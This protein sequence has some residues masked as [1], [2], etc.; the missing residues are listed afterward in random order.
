MLEAFKDKIQPLVVAGSVPPSSA[1]L[2]GPQAGQVPANPSVFALPVL[3]LL[4]VSLQTL[5]C[6]LSLKNGEGHL[7]GSV[8]EH[9]PLA[10]GVILGSWDQVQH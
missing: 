2:S 7:S 8:V 4:C 10:Q 5:S 6:F 1:W 3:C 9:L